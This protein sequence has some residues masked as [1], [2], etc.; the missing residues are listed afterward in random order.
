MLFNASPTT[1]SMYM[2]VISLG[3]VNRN[4]PL[5]VDIISL[6]DSL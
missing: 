5:R 6:N 3:F 1:G 4:F 2:H